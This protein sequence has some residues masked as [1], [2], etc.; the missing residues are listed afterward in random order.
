M[1]FFFI[2]IYNV[3]IAK[4]YY[5]NGSHNSAIEPMPHKTVHLNFRVS[6][7]YRSYTTKKSLKWFVPDEPFSF[8]PSKF[9]S[10]T[11][12][13]VTTSIQNLTFNTWE[14]LPRT[15]G[16]GAPLQDA[17]IRIVCEVNEKVHINTK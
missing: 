14:L 13:S 7:R 3:H 10:V 11:H 4:Q 5:N 16:Q 8:S 9:I 12:S 17:N 2:L 15:W 1:F 6:F